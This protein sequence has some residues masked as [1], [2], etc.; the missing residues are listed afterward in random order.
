MAV[1][2]RALGGA[3]AMAEPAADWCNRRLAVPS[4]RNVISEALSM[5]NQRFGL[6][7]LV[8]AF[9]LGLTVGFGFFCGLGGAVF[10]GSARGCG[11]EIHAT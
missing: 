7:G 11:D 9:C 5:R 3:D 8:C 1:P 4:F 10:G 6:T 2:P